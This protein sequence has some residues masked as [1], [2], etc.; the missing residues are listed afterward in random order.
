MLVGLRATLPPRAVG[1]DSH[2]IRRQASMSTA[3][4]H[5]VNGVCDGKVRCHLSRSARPLLLC[6]AC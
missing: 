3:T 1:L 6:N 5:C 4:F 2:V